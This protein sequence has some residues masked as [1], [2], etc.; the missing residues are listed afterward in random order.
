MSLR[1]RVAA[2][3]RIRVD[4]RPVISVYLNTRWADEQQRD[5]ARGFIKAELRRAREG[6]TPR[7]LSAD[8]DWIETETERC[9]AQA[10]HVS[11]HGVALFAC[12]AIGLR[13]IVPVAVGCDDLFVVS[14]RPVLSP[15]VALLDEVPAT[16]VVAVD[17]TS[18]RLVPLAADGR[19]EEVLLEHAVEGRHRRGGW[20]LLAQ[21]RYQRHI[22]NQRAEHFTAVAETLAHLVRE[23][24]IAAIVLAGDARSVGALRERLRP[25]LAARVVGT[26]SAARHEPAALL[27]ERAS[28]LV[29]EARRARD[30]EEVERV[31]TEAAKGGRAVVGVR[32]TLDALERGAVQR[33]FVAKD[34][35]ARE[36]VVDR[37][38]TTGGDVEVVDGDAS[39]A[40][41]GGVAARLRYRLRARR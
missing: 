2:L 36:Q 25:S 19:G 26:M 20:A 37:V 24:A 10:D 18:A 12:E 9:I 21:S 5:R 6:D 13:E 38:L 3:A 27:V 41:V 23:R 30:A 40:R 34:F 14:D 1:E 7:V 32:P 33:L 28:H 22:A 39:L 16:V 8:L 29:A 31:I 17:G 15:L 11:A 35:V 4:A